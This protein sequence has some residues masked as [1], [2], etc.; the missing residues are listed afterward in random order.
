MHDTSPS[1]IESAS[2]P[3]PSSL[4]YFGWL[5]PLSIELSGG[6][7]QHDPRVVCGSARPPASAAAARTFTEQDL[8]GIRLGTVGAR[9]KPFELAGAAKPDAVTQQSLFVESVADTMVGDLEPA[10]KA[11]LGRVIDA[12]YDLARIA[13]DPATHDPT[14]PVSCCAH[15]PP[16]SLDPLPKM[17]GWREIA[18]FDYE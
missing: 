16:A 4:T 8:P 12:C 11:V 18:S 5:A 10:E 1:S 7:E 6:R 9:I 15:S 13:A 14:P 2:T 3:L 17:S